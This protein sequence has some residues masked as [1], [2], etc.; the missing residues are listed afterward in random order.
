MSYS[1]WTNYQTYCVNLWLTKEEGASAWVYG[2]ANSSG[3]IYN[4]VERL[5]ETI[6]EINPI[7]GV[8]EEDKSLELIA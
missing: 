7:E 8:A 2:L 6:E 4:K 1:G 3:T 5:K